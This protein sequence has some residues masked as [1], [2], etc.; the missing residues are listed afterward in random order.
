MWAHRM[1]KEQPGDALDLGINT[2]FVLGQ[3][4]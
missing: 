1:G 4:P 2:G 3:Q